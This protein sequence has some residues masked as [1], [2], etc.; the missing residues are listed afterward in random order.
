MAANKYA[1]AHSG[2]LAPH[3][4]G[5]NFKQ[6]TLANGPLLKRA[7]SSSSPSSPPPPPPSYPSPSHPHP[8][9]HI[10]IS[11]LQSLFSPPP[12]LHHFPQQFMPPGQCPEVPMDSFLWIY[13]TQC[14]AIF[15]DYW[16]TPDY[17]TLHY[18]YSSW[19]CHTIHSPTRHTF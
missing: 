9:L 6:C 15:L 2:A 17:S 3:A 5:I 19:N 14:Q 18:T 1:I 12:L 10:I 8:P 16:A 7:S 11:P 4:P 13:P